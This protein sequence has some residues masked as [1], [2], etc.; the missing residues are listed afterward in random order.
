LHN[1]K[2]WGLLTSEGRSIK[3]RRLSV[4]WPSKPDAR[5][6]QLEPKAKQPT[7]TLVNFAFTQHEPIT[8]P[9]PPA[10]RKINTPLGPWNTEGA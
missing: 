10:V 2:V 7:G 4:Y 3:G 1:A 8:L 9:P 5:W 6:N